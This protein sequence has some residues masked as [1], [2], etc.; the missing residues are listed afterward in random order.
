MSNRNAT[1][2]W[3]GYS[4]QGYVG[5]FVSLRDMRKLISEGK[6]DEFD[7]HFLEYEN[8]ED[9]AIS[10][11]RA[12]ATKELLS[13]HQVKAYY[14]Q[15]HLLST[16]KL[17]FTGAPI[18]K[19]DAD[20][21]LSKDSEGKKIETGNYESGQWCDSENFLH[22]VENINNWPINNDFSSVQGNPN[23]IKRFEYS[24]NVFFCGTDQISNL[25]ITELISDDFHTG[26][27]GAAGMSLKRITF[28]LDLKIRNEHATKDSKSNYEIRFSFKDLLD[29]IHDSK[30][31]SQNEVTYVEICFMKFI[32]KL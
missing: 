27:H 12:G 29:I 24:P 28:E 13:V 3:S 8:N 23:N 30:D 22:T 26:N 4:H 2:S 31:I 1:A 25:I 5:I 21:K 6:Q 32:M 14:S 15:G 11:Q 9:V 7:L 19:L 20:G 17:V 16:Y 10:K 18:Y